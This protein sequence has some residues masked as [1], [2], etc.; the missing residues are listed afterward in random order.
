MLGVSETYSGGRI[1]TERETGGIKACVGVEGEVKRARGNEGSDL[2]GAGWLDHWPPCALWILFSLQ[3][4][5]EEELVAMEDAL[6]LGDSDSA[7]FLTAEG[8]SSNDEAD[9]TGLSEEEG[10]GPAGA[11]APGQRGERPRALNKSFS[12]RAIR[13]GGR[14]IKSKANMGREGGSASAERAYKKW[15]QPA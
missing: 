11:E 5:Q 15:R 7:R 9:G 8:V 3:M 12:L 6:S 13:P 10:E 4:S 1:G 2:P 14:R